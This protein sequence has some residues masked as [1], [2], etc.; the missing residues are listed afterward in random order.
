MTSTIPGIERDLYFS[1]VK[2]G[3]CSALQ[4]YRSHSINHI[5]MDNEEGTES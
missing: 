1:P 3:E 2:V 5:T 4:P